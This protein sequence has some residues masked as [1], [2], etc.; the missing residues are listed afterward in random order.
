[1]GVLMK[2]RIPHYNGYAIRGSHI[3]YNLK[4]K[5]SSAYFDFFTYTR[6]YVT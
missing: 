1:M 2:R 4:S 6:I 3:P 5:E